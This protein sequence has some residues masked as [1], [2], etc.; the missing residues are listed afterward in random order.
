[1]TYSYIECTAVLKSVDSRCFMLPYFQIVPSL[2]ASPC[3]PAALRR[4][5]VCHA[6][7]FHESCGERTS[8]CN[9]TESTFIE[10]ADWSSRRFHAARQLLETRETISPASSRATCLSQMYVQ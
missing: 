5:C 8:H 10:F 6:E 2:S 9:H 1:M 3:S 7:L 4:V